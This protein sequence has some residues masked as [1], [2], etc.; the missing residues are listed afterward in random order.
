MVIRIWLCLVVCSSAWAQPYTVESV[1][2]VKV[3][4]NKY[5]SNPDGILRQETV[6]ELDRK[7]KELEV[8]TTAQVAVVVLQSIGD[9]EIFTFA[10][11]LFTHWGIGAG[12]KD[13]GLLVLLVMDLRTVRFHT[14][15]GLEGILP[16]VICKRIEMEQMVPK[17]KEGKND[18]AMLA[19]LDGVIRVLTDPAYA[20]EIWEA[21]ARA[22]SG[23]SVF[24][25]VALIG[26][27][28]ILLI[29]FLVNRR[30]FAD[31]R[32][33]VSTAYSELRLG[34][35]AWFLEFG[36]VPAAILA[37]FQTSTLIDPV[38]ECV[39]ALYGYFMLT[40]VHKRFRMTKTV[41]RFLKDGKYK[42]VVDFFDTYSRTWLVWGILFPIPFLPHYFW[43]K[44]RIGYYRNHPRNCESCRKPVR[45]LDEAADDAYLS[46]AQVFEEG[47]HSVDYDV[48]LCESCGAYSPLVYQNKRSK[49]ASC[50]T[51]K[52]K[53][54]YKTGEKTI[55][56]PTESSSGKG[57]RYRACKFC[58]H[59]ATESYSIPRLTS[60]SDSSSSGGGGSSGGSF[61][62]GS[63]GGGGASSSW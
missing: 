5:V 60:S 42:K 63:S 19:G 20:D 12:Q 36:L 46:K 31:S 39:M 40:L 59:T 41:N 3:Q 29:V 13:N 57:E 33:P 7:L 55:R 24:F 30:S 17:F 11:N 16:D 6:D 37:L 32:K 21:E 27:S 50:P 47:L 25:P 9:E 49:Y 14:G 22:Q 10:Q 35:A 2:N 1:P 48:W 45:K 28:I 18:E 38:L 4:S 43:Y 54:Y 15:Q 61:G 51:C 44:R 62:G 26:G 53:A 8:Q 58:G 23:W 52:T 34:K 56:E